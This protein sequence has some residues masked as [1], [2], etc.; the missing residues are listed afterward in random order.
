[1]YR[2]ASTTPAMLV[3]YF[4]GIGVDRR[5]VYE[6]LLE[7]RGPHYSVTAVGAN[8]RGAGDIRGA[9]ALRRWF[10]HTPRET[11]NRR[12]YAGS[13]SWRALLTLLRAACGANL[14]EYG[15]RFCYVLPSVPAQ[16]RTLANLVPPH[17]RFDGSLPLHPQLWQTGRSLDTLP[18]EHHTRACCDERFFGDERRSWTLPAWP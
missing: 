10:G 11:G 2:T 8:S 7:Q 14:A 15:Q 5:S 3:A 12:L 16:P 13:D 18:I 9:A 4:G 1:M 17:L 6:V